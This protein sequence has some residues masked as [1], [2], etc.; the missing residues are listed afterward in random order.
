MNFSTTQVNSGAGQIAAHAKNEAELWK[1]GADINEQTED[2]LT[3]M[4][5][6]AES[7]IQVE[8]DT[9]AGR[10][11]I[12]NFRTMSGFYGPGL[13]GEALFAGDRELLEEL[14]L[15]THGVKVDLL[16]NGIENFFMMEDAMGARGEIENNINEQF[17][18]WM[19]REK[20][21]QG[22][23]SL[24]HQVSTENHMVANGAGTPDDITADDHLSPDDITD[25]A[26]L[27]EPMGGVP[28]YLGRDGAGNKVYGACFLTTKVGG[29]GLKTDADY[30]QAQRDAGVRG[31]ENLLF[32]G[33]TSMIDGNIIKDWNVIDHDGVGPVGSVLNPKA[34]LGVKIV[35]GTTASMTAASGG[36][37]ICGG[38][39]AAAAAKTKM[40]FFRYFPKFAFP[41]LGGGALSVNASTHYLIGTNEFY[42]RIVNP[43]NAP[44]EGSEVIR[45]K[46]GIFRCSANGFTA[47]GNELTVNQRLAAAASGIAAT[48]VGSVTYN[49]AVHTE[50]FVEGA[51]VVLCSKDGTPIGR[52]LGLYK[53]AMRRAYGAFR[54]RRMTDSRE[55]GAVKELY[56]ASIFGQKPRQNANDKFPGVVV[57]WHAVKYQGWNCAPAP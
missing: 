21:N 4:E 24:V 43:S 11:H 32:K 38:G 15:R 48:T 16:R 35:A 17:G 13:Q 9:S 44:N 23:M 47:S 5:G 37:G 45:N 50:T 27:L 7:L 10:G 54:N 18:A 1:K 3:A 39:N 41:F 55:G 29:N 51:L 30:K 42:V 57:L 26:A 28:A 14:K 34:F 2:I 56:I 12:V 53:R 25:A 49:S 8:T 20:T 40:P 33:G 19:G 31:S 6:G 46:W 36:R 52:S 22:L